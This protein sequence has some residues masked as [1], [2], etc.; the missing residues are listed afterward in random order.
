MTTSTIDN[1]LA[2]ETS[3]YLQQ[4]ASNPVAWQPWDD[5]A[6]AIAVREDKPIFLSIGYS[7]CYWCHVMEEECFADAEVAALLNRYFVPIKVDREERP[8]LDQQYM[9]A[10]RLLTG[11]GGWPDSVWL[12]PDGRPWMAATYLPKPDFIRTLEALVGYWRDRRGE[13]EAQAGQVLAQMDGL[14]T[15]PAGRSG[16]TGRVAADRQLVDAAVTTLRRDFDPQH[17]GFGTAPKFPPHGALRLLLHVCRQSADRELVHIITRTLDAMWLGGLH[18]HV[19]GGFHRYATDAAWLAP[20][21]EKMLYDNAQLLRI[22]TEAHLLLGTGRYRRAAEE[23]VAWLDAEMTAATGAFI[24]AIDAGEP[25]QEGA[26]Y[27]WRRKEVTAVLGEDEGAL[28]AEVYKLSTEGNHRDER[29]GSRT[30]TNLPHLSRPLAALAAEWGEDPDALARRT[31]AWRRDLLE[32]RRRRPQPRHDGKILTGWNGLAIAALAYAG[33]HLGED[34]WTARAARAAEALLKGSVTAEGRLLRLPAVPGR[35]GLPAYLDDHAYLVDGLLELHAATGERDWLTAAQGLGDGI[36][37]HFIDTAR[38]GFH[39]TADFHEDLLLRDKHLRGGGNLPDPNGTAARVLLALDR[40]SDDPRFGEEASRTL[41]ALAELPATDPHGL[42]DLVLATAIA[43][44]RPAGDQLPPADVERRLAVITARLYA[45]TTTIAPG[46][47]FELALA[48]D[49]DAGWHLWVPL[50]EKMDVVPTRIMIAA[51]NRLRPGAWRQPDPGELPEPS[52]AG[53]RAVYTGRIWY[54]LPVA[55]TADAADGPAS[56][57]LTLVT[58]ACSEDSCAEPRTDE[59]TLSLMIE[60][61]A[62][63]HRRYP[64]IFL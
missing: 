55:V 35:T 30:G 16:W 4:H 38:G 6:L 44:D 37:A 22:Y 47:R 39:Y 27:R 13:V 3:P 21:F 36:L 49:V 14:A 31:A 41:A 46:G 60:T 1:R 8:D 48:L 7:T 2:H 20:H 24:T 34:A 51:D 32:E 63:P 54:R 5:Q 45:S 17:G 15:G 25:G 56:L 10:T 50:A 58:Q 53:G 40:H 62:E 12:T 28:C 42:E 59:L 43:L 64:G 57:T 19:G 26:V 29:T 33:R 61:D 18:D 52:A 11:G 9:L 23:I